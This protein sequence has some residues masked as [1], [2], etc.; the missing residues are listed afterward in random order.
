MMMALR[1][2]EGE[3]RDFEEMQERKRGKGVGEDHLMI[4]SRNVSFLF[5]SNDQTPP[6]TSL[7]PYFIL[8]LSFLPSLS[9]LLPYKVLES[10]ISSD[11]RVL[12]SRTNM[13][14][15]PIQTAP[16]GQ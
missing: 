1:M 16:S 4:G 11:N 6:Q 2:E 9:P 15:T 3:R 8:I 13:S 7:Q 14:R 5:L 10:H 12:G